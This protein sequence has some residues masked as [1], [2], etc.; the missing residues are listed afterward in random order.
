MP[1]TSL[2]SIF[3]TDWRE[4]KAARPRL[5]VGVHVTVI[6]GPTVAPGISARIAP[7]D[8]C[9]A[10]SGHSGAPYTGAPP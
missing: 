7:I 1:V 3:P 5:R 10:Q 4:G 6:P 2:V 9:L 8:V